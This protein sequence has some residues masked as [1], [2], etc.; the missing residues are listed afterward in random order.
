MERWK[1]A[2]NALLKE[3]A[4]NTQRE[5]YICICIDIHIYI[6]HTVELYT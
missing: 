5:I 4:V 2:H 1:G 3:N 6:G